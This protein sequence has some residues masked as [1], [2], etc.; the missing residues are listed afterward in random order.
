MSQRS[1]I[2]SPE[3]RGTMNSNS[4]ES[5]SNSRKLKVNHVFNQTQ[6]NGWVDARLLPSKGFDSTATK[7]KPRLVSN[8][9]TGNSME[10]TGPGDSTQH[11]NFSRMFSPAGFQLAPKSIKVRDTLS[12]ST[13]GVLSGDSKVTSQLSGMVL[14]GDATVSEL[15]SHV[16]TGGPT[17]GLS[18]VNGQVNHSSKL[19]EEGQLSNGSSSIR[20]QSLP[21]INIGQTT[22]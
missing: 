10:P 13:V 20:C 14:N 6:K 17:K 2:D 22:H 16:G 18:T 15:P 3:I 7:G 9:S 8:G 12:Q 11:E 5:P 4:A 21:I 19:L 1:N